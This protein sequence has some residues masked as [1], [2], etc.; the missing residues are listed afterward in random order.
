[1]GRSVTTAYDAIYARRFDE[2]WEILGRVGIFRTEEREE[3]AQN[4]FCAV[5]VHLRAER[6]KG[7]H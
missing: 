5:H 1:M 4:V 7:T 6:P 2:V 3:V